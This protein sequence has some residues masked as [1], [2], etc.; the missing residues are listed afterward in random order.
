MFTFALSVSFN[1]RFP[2][3]GEP[4]KKRSDPGARPRPNMG[5]SSVP[6][7]EDFVR[8]R[9]FSCAFKSS[10]ADIVGFLSSSGFSGEKM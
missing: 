1:F 4:S 2:N 3:L 5:A 8:L 9:S 6:V 7:D 10:E